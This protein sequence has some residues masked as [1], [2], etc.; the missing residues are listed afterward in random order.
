MKLILIKIIICVCLLLSNAWAKEIFSE[1]SVSTAGVKIGEF[2][3]KLDLY[4]GYYKI[5]INLKST[6][7]ISSFY[8]FEGEY[9]SSGILQDRT[10]KSRNY[11]QFWETKKKTKIIEIKFTDELIN[12]EQIPKEDEA[13]RINFSDLSGYNDPLTS[14]L[15]VLINSKSVNTID[16]RRIYSMKKNSKED[17]LNKVSIQIKEYKNIWADHDRNDL[18]K[19][20]F[21]LEDNNFLPLSIN[22]FYKKRVF[23]LKKI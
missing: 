19:I 8:N 14:F 9:L 17:N 20:E 18:K 5:Q 4:D 10:F 7:L 16:G 11:K 13:P 3:W 23:K 6:G 15:N 2:S 1:Y 21:F 12:I 22:I